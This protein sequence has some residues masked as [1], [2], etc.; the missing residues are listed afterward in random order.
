MKP[1][2][3]LIF[4]VLVMEEEFGEDMA[5]YRKLM[6]YL[7]HLLEFLET[8]RDVSFSLE[9][10]AG[11]ALELREK[12]PRLFDQLRELVKNGQIDLVEGSY[13]QPHFH[14]IGSE[15]NIRQF[16]YGLETLQELFGVK[17]DLYFRQ[18]SSFHHQLPQILSRFGFR[19]ACTPSIGQTIFTFQRSTLNRPGFIRTSGL[20][21]FPGGF[22]PR[23][24]IEALRGQQMGI[25]IGLE[26]SRLPY[27][28]TEPMSIQ[29]CLDREHRALFTQ[30]VGLT[31]SNFYHDHPDHCL[32]PT[33]NSWDEIQVTKE[34]IRFVTA[35]Q[36][37]SEVMEGLPVC[38]EMNIM[39]ATAYCEGHWGELCQVSNRQAEYTILQAETILSMAHCMGL[40]A[41]VSNREKLRRAWKE[42][43]S[44]QHHDMLTMGVRKMAEAS[45][46]W[47]SQ[48]TRS[49]REV[50]QETASSLVKQVR[51]VPVRHQVSQSLV[52][53]NTLAWPRT[54][55]TRTRVTLDKG[56]H[57]E[58]GIFDDQGRA[59]R[60]DYW[61][62]ERHEDGSIREAEIIWEVSDIPAVGYCTFFLGEKTRGEESR[63]KL[64]IRDEEEIIITNENMEVCFGRRNCGIQWIREL[65]S[66]EVVFGQSEESL[67]AELHA[68]TDPSGENR[69]FRSG[70]GQ[71]TLFSGNYF[72]RLVVQG[73]NIF[74]HYAQ[75]FLI[76]PT[77]PR[78]DIKTTVSIDKLV[79]IGEF[80]RQQ[81]KLRI[82]FP[83]QIQGG[84]SY[85]IPFGAVELES[86]RKFF[87]VSWTAV[88]NGLAGGLVVHRGTMLHLF[89]K[90]SLSNI[91][92]VA[93]RKWSMDWENLFISMDQRFKGRRRY[94]HSI[95]CYPGAVEG[96][97]ATRRAMEVNHPL[98]TIFTSP[99][100]GPWPSRK[101][102]IQVEPENIIVTALIPRKNS[103]LLR[104]Y[105]SGGKRTAATVRIWKP[106][107]A[108]EEELNGQTLVKYP[109]GSE[110]RLDVGP[111]QIKN[112]S[113]EG[114]MKT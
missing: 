103:I 106:I 8:N 102:L 23:N 33:P 60:S 107:A 90:N 12:Y 26:G 112:L 50:L 62:L 77:I 108:T 48:A 100:Q 96:A 92:L 16:E 79:E 58:I 94:Q 21:G 43:L 4:H 109:P 64:L 20:Y 46:S 95:M 81:S 51:T 68:I 97:S 110:I 111:W 86:D 10:S 74:G 61:V 73:K 47:S 35:A 49:C 52:V 41:D 42:I 6:V 55:Y 80:H 19:Y 101:S 82:V 7:R 99:H 3:T 29:D 66:K 13:S 11:E 84:V 53:I 44:S 59:V 89:K 15:S 36:N 38:H 28:F 69:S 76:G 24:K 71:I 25:W 105:E 27:I 78:I 40:P 75:E 22:I 45:A 67:V 9:L 31:P 63:E 14:A 88:N 17:V 32:H 34:N 54:G 65:T 91:L 30:E 56:K 93:N 98:L 83:L 70:E 85:D 57:R 72:A 39:T 2:F 104:L 37:V 114:E 18:E 113:L 87:P 5:L 1:L